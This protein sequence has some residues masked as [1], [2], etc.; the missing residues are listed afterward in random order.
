MAQIGTTK[1]PINGVIEE[2]PIFEPSDLDTPVARTAVGGAIGAYAVFD[3]AEDVAYPQL[4]I[5]HPTYGTLA[6][7]N[8]ATLVMPIDDFEH[9]NLADHYDDD[10]STW[11]TQTAAAFEGTYGFVED[12]TGSGND[13]WSF[14]SD[15]PNYNGTN[16]P[17]TLE[18]YPERGEGEF[19]WFLNFHTDPV[20][21]LRRIQ[22][23][24]QGTSRGDNG[25][26]IEF[27]EDSA[28]AGEM[29]IRLQS[30]LSNIGGQGVGWDDFTYQTDHWYRV[31]IEMESPDGHWLDIYEE[32]G[33][34]VVSIGD[35]T[36]ADH[37]IGGIL[38]WSS[39]STDTYFDEW[40]YT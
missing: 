25:Y 16:Q 36:E 35:S 30:N 11:D 31:V 20:N 7:H 15:D 1:V 24:M 39:S 2:V 10:I 17:E 22:Y 23:C 33:T 19:E 34:N 5:E 29:R 12:T 40:R 6:F 9:N 32:D 8:E 13:I 37:D 28:A 18:S 27:E 3:P 26:R 21:T 14:P 4:R 38:H